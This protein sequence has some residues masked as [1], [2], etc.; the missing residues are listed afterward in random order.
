MRRRTNC[1]EPAA[2]LLP[3][4]AKSCWMWSL[5]DGPAVRAI[6]LSSKLNYPA[7]NAYCAKSMPSDAIRGVAHRFYEQNTRKLGFARGTLMSGA[8]TPFIGWLE[9]SERSRTRLSRD[10]NLAALPLCPYTSAVPKM[11]MILN[12]G[13]V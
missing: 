13:I 9:A 6:A 2:P 12:P 1:P 3:A 5:R 7:N 4:G 8:N 11:D 10:Q